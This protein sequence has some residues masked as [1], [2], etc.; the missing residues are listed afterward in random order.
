MSDRV[1]P[2]NGASDVGAG[3]IVQ[4]QVACMYGVQLKDGTIRH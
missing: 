3:I 4:R 2:K 1:R